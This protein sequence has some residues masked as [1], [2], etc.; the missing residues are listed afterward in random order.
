MRLGLLAMSG[1]RVIDPQLAW[2]GVT[3]P[4]A[5]VGLSDGLGLPGGFT[6]TDLSAG[7]L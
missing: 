6:E 5:I 3:T 4:D 7:G 1:L 2:L